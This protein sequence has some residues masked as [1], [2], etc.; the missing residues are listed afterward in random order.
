[1]EALV[2]LTTVPDAEAAD[3]LA[4][5]LIERKVAA[6]VNI[7][8]A[9]RSIYHWQGNV[10]Q[11]NEVPL[12]IKTTRS[13]YAE[14]EALIVGVHP[15]EV[16]EIIALPIVAGLPSYLNWLEQETNRNIDG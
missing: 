5:Q 4:R 13:C 11:S 2:V 3:K 16:P 8:P 12:L 7:L 9:A 14:L 15:Y 1:M 6:C 10:E